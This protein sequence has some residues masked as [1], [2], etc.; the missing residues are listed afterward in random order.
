MNPQEGTESQPLSGVWFGEMAG[1]FGRKLAGGFGNKLGIEFK[2][3]VAA[4]YFP[5]HY[6]PA[7]VDFE[8]GRSVYPDLYVDFAD[9]H[10]D[11][12]PTALAARAWLAG[13]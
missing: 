10:K 11:C 5:G 9:E 7:C 6:C 4:H 12:G 3:L 2:V 1:S 8:R 13:A